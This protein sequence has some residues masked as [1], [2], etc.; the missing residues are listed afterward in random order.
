MAH[1]DAGKT[2]TTERILYYTGVRRTRS[3]RPTTAPPPW[4]GWSQEQERGVTITA[5]ATT[6][7]WKGKDDETY[8]FQIID[9]PGP[10]GLHRRGRALPARP[11]RHR[12]RLRRQGAACAA[13][14]RDR[15]AS[16]RQLRR[17]AHRVYINKMRPRG[18][19]LLRRAVQ[20]MIRIV[21][22]A[23]AV[24]ASSCPSAP[25]TTSGASSTWSTM[26]A[27]DFKDDDKGMTYPEPMDAIPAEFAD[28]AE[29]GAPGAARGC[30][31]LRR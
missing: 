11:R 24:A 10:R 17:A 5:A 26:T 20:T 29:L 16:G 19:R 7:F 25:R 8:R 14:V 22:T 1:I 15:V 3:A 18:R 9:T 28:E 27:R 6:C 21:C 13:A 23:N 2:T 30:R 4:T 12:R 31:R